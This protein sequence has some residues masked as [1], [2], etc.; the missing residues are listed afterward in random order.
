MQQAQQDA[1]EQERRRKG[2]AKTLLAG[3]TG[4]YTPEGKKTLLG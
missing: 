2:I 3:E 1:L 4:G